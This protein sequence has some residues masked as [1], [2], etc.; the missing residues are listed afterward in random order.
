VVAERGGKVVDLAKG[1]KFA[2]LGFDFRRFTSQPV[3]R[4]I[5]LVNPEA[6]RL[7]LAAV[8]KAMALRRTRPVQGLPGSATGGGAESQSSMIGHI[9]LR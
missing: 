5:E 4:V 9:N 6:K 3:E 8:D 7:L 1:E 2:F